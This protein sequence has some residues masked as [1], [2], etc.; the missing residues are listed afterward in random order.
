MVSEVEPQSF[1]SLLLRHPS[2]HVGG[3]RPPELCGG[4]HKA[5]RIAKTQLNQLRKPY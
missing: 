1:K 5:W 3:W 4:R 2:Q